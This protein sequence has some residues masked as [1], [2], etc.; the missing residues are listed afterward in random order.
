[1][2]SERKGV[3][4]GGN[5]GKGWALVTGASGGI[6]RE[7]ARAFASR[8][9]DLILTARNEEAL[10][11]LAQEFGAAHAVRAKTMA[12]DLGVPGA[13]EAMAVAIERAGVAVEILVNNAGVIFEG[14][15]TSIAL[16]NHLRLLQI[17]VVALTSLTHLFLPR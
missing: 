2:T 12:V 14:D 10:A 17:N 6:G 9:Y 7:L 4:G 8:G 15:F 5:S 13:A 3:A 11:A 1:M 16:E